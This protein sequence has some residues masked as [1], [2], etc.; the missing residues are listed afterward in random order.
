MLTGMALMNSRQYIQ[1][2]ELF[3][4]IQAWL[5]DRLSSPVDDSIVSLPGN[6]NPSNNQ[7]RK[8]NINVHKL[9]MTAHA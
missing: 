1:A 9:T 8:S 3:R 4:K 6:Y 2:C 7:F 5:I